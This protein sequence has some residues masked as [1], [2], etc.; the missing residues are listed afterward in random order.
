[1][2]ILALERIGCMNDPYKVLGVSPGASEQEIKKAYRDL[3][4][5]YHPDNYHDNPLA[6]LAQEKMKE[7][8]EAYDAIMKNRSGGNSGYYQGSSTSGSYNSYSSGYSSGGSVYDE[9]RRDISSGNLD[10]AQQ[11]LNNI[12]NRDAQ[13]YFL[14]G[15]VNYSRGWIDEARRN[16]QTASSMEPHNLEYQQAVI[17]ASRGQASP[18]G[19]STAGNFNADQACNM[20]SSLMCADCCCEC[21]GGDLIRCI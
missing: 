5:K 12:Q 17:R 18:F 13:W 4:R 1:M 19:R 16:F 9:I 21:M 11:K 3:A 6:D 10:R 15:S 8:N 20:C 7:I 14:M 2:G